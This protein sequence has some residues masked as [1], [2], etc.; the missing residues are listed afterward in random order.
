MSPIRALKNDVSALELF[1]MPGSAVSA[2]AALE[3]MDGR[4]LAIVPFASRYTQLIQEAIERKKL[5]AAG[6]TTNGGVIT[7]R[8]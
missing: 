5:G 6:I 3:I 2:I 4:T 1:G 8:I 7:V